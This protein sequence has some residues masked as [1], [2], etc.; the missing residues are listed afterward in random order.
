MALYDTCHG[1]GLH[2]HLYDR[3]EKEFTQTPLRSVASYEDMDDWLAYALQR[4][5]EHWQDN[6]RRS[7]RGY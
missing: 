3:R 6:E 7:D 1:K 4:V 5:T 2:V